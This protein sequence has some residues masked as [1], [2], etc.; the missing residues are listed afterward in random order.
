M[1]YEPNGD[2]YDDEYSLEVYEDEYPLEDEPSDLC[3]N[4]ECPDCYPQENENDVVS[5]TPVTWT[6]GTNTETSVPSFVADSGMLEASLNE[7]QASFEREV[8]MPE[9]PEVNP[10][11]TPVEENTGPTRP[12]PV[13]EIPRVYF[14]S[15]TGRSIRPGYSRA[16]VDVGCNVQVSFWDTTP[17]RARVSYTRLKEWLIENQ[18]YFSASSDD[19]FSDAGLSASIPYYFVLCNADHRGRG[20]IDPAVLLSQ[21]DCACGRELEFPTLKCPDCE[22]PQYCSVCRGFSS[23][24]SYDDSLGTFCDACSATCETCEERYHA[25]NGRCTSCYPRTRCHGCSALM[26][27]GQDSINAF[28]FPDD[29]MEYSFCDRCYRNMCHACGEIQAEGNILE[30]EGHRCTACVS[31]NSFE[32]WD[33]NSQLE[34]NALLIPT[35]PG[36]ETIRLVGIEIEG[37]NGDSIEGREG[38]NT[39]ARALYDAGLS[40]SYAMNGY[41]SGTRSKV[42]VERDSSVDWEM[43][44]GPLN[45]A[46]PQDVD[47]LNSSVRMVRGF[48]NDKTL[49]LDMRAGLH[50]HVGAERVAF[51]NAYNLHKLYMYME[52]FLYRLGAAKWPY[53]RSV[54]RRGRDQAGKSPITEG[55][56]NFARTFAGQRYYGLSFDNYFA[57]YFESCECGARRYGLF[58]ECTCELGKCTFEF[59][60]FNTTANT[61]KIHAYLAICQALVAKAVELDEIKD[62]S[63]YPAL[64]FTKTKVSDLHHAT[65][66]KLVR[67]WEK[68]IVFVNEQLPLTPEEKRSIHYC[69]MNSE[70]GK[71]VSNAD[72]LL[73]T[74][75]N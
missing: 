61:I 33:E 74:E 7:I 37:A 1:P 54:N 64:D 60:L 43:V 11:E 65:R 34:S 70:M 73:E 27:V 50:V 59:R 10:E 56:L 14:T 42:Y 46:N 69:I 51:H 30:D 44:I 21:P 62:A 24:I 41:H 57:R 67:E 9:T 19:A 58:D 15:N 68:R 5:E 4:P 72:I 66:G 71:L 55:K 23:G 35:I 18:F 75:D 36:R 63:Q 26:Y 48:I 28:T 20:V 49:K 3:G 25:S 12:V 22:A 6:F 45:V 2:W 29:S 39:L 32:E 17:D 13:P 16:I 47:L 53:H 52:D 40:G 31:R 38:G 8:E